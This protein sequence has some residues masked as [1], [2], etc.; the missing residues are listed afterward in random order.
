MTKLDTL[1]L[2]VFYILASD[3][4]LFKRCLENIIAYRKNLHP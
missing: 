1:Y 4:E 2:E 3:Y